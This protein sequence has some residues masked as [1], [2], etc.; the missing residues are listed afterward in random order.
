MKIKQ[1]NPQQGPIVFSEHHP[2]QEPLSGKDRIFRRGKING[3]NVEFL[4]RFENAE[5]PR[6]SFHFD[7]IWYYTDDNRYLFDLLS[8]VQPDLDFEIVE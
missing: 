2:N 1:A 4:R 3:R 8:S 5:T 6:V 7:G